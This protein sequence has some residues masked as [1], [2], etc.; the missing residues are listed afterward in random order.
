MSYPSVTYSF[1]NATSINAVQVNQNF[2]D[3]I[4]GVSDTTKDIG[5]NKCNASNI[6]PSTDIYSTAWT[7]YSSTST[8]VG[9]SSFYTKNIYYKKIG[10][11][12]FVWFFLHGIPSTTPNGLVLTFTLPIAFN[13][14]MTNIKIAL[15]GNDGGTNPTRVVGRFTS[16]NVFRCYLTGYDGEYGITS[17][18]TS[19]PS[20]S[21]KLCYGNFFYEV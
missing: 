17:D 10:T 1:T 15:Y 3:L 2:N 11:T 21:H 7:D 19:S 8:I 13:A 6:I 20:S 14:T 18:W 5:I 9:F 4:N 16:T 12:I